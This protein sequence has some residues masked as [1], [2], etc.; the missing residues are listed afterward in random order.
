V[1]LLFGPSAAG[2]AYIPAF[3]DVVFMVEGNASMYLGSPRM[4]EM[5]IGQITTLEEMGGAR[6][7]CSVSGCGDLLAR[8]EPEAIEACRRYLSYLPLAGRRRAARDGGA[9]SLRRSR[10]DRVA[11]PE[12]G[13]QAL[14]HARV[15]ERI[16]DAGSVF[17]I[18]RLFAGEILTA[19]ARIEGR[20]IGIVANQP[21]VKGGVLFVDSADK[22]TRFISLCDAFGLPL[23]FLA[24]VP[25]F[26]VGKHVERQGIIRAG[27]KMIM[28][29]SDATVPRLSV[30]VRKAYGAGLYAMSG[31]GFAP[32]ACLALPGSMIAV[33][34]PE[35]AVNAVYF[36]RLQGLPEDERAAEEQRLREEY[37]QDVDIE[38]LASE[39]AIDGIVPAASLRDEIA[40]RLRVAPRATRPGPRETAH[41]H[42]RLRLRPSRGALAPVASGVA[43]VGRAASRAGP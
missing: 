22:A 37:R 28:A 12:G 40:A 21:K 1:C 42:S 4:A 10:R 15:I 24:D 26:M 43:A 35:A 7:H 27:A 31:P 30:V 20:P 5:V 17:E 9:A 23:L 41:C 38:R 3:C 34:G 18:K 11:D 19:F 36:N 14:R 33:M 25:G 13:E 39:L 6:M 29:V 32:D 2:G 16:V 8:T